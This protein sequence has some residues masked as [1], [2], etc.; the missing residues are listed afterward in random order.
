MVIAGCALALPLLAWALPRAARYLCP[1]SLSAALL[2]GSSLVAA[3]GAAA[4]AGREA[5]WTA[6]DDV[7]WVVALASLGLLGGIGSAPITVATLLFGLAAMALAVRVPPTRLVAAACAATVLGPLAR[8]AAGA[9]TES[10][11][12]L[13]L[14]SALIGAAHVAAARATHSLAYVL[15]E[16]EALLTERRTTTRARAHTP[17]TAP[18]RA[19]RAA[20]G[21]GSSS[22]VDL[23]ALEAI[24]A[25]PPSDDVGWEGLIEKLRVS[26]SSLCDAA[27]V[28]AS[29]HAEVQ[30]LASPSPKMRTNVLRIAQEAANHVLR[31][32]SP[33]SIAVTLRRG[34]GGLLLEVQDDGRVGENVRSR[35][36]LA[37]LRGRVVPLGGSAELHRRDAGW[38]MQV[39]LPCE[40]LN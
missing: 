12:S 21:A 24:A 38:V 4:W 3:S 27:G 19:R 23:A 40:Q 30:G 22:V 33:T 18:N 1:A 31:D 25:T 17:A 13:T 16:R 9:G 35:R 20:G 11:V 28:A 5:H 6:A 14:V 34:D 39:K 10:V 8:L 26:V 32:A 7:A 37:S 29:V 2:A 36:G 15:A